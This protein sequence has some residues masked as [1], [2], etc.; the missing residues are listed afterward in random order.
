M[1]LPIAGMLAAFLSFVLATPFV[2]TLRRPNLEFSDP[3]SH[4]TLGT[5][6][7]LVQHSAFGLLLVGFFVP[8]L[9]LGRRP[10]GQV[11]IATLV[12]SVVGGLLSVGFDAMLDSIAISLDRSSKRTETGLGGAGSFIVPHFYGLFQTI[13]LAFP[14]AFASGATKNRFKRAFLATAVGTVLSAI[15]RNVI[16]IVMIPFAI[17]S[18]MNAVS[19]NP[20]DLSGVLAASIPSWQASAIAVGLALGLTMGFVEYVTRTGV[21][22]RVYARNEFKEWE[23]AGSH[24]RIGSGEVEIRVDS[25]HGVEPIH[26]VLSSQGNQHVLDSRFAPTLVNGIPIG[27]QPL[28][29]GDWIQ[30]GD[31]EMIYLAKDGSGGF[32]MTRRPAQAPLTTN[33]TAVPATPADQRPLSLVDSSGARFVLAG[34][35]HT[36]GRDLGN[37]I[38]LAKHT[39][40]S[41]RHAVISKTQHGEELRDAGS[42][43]GTF[44]NGLRLTEPVLLSP[45][46]RVAFGSATF[47]V[48]G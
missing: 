16:G 11:L 44:H 40:V 36:V 45:G 22:R 24:L 9:L 17:S 47:I 4:Y 18:M 28:R 29:H 14:I 32:D 38:V 21:L 10:I 23:L 46:D 12:W 35:E 39:T 43:N 1:P 26:A 42:S 19:K 33:L 34:G 13:A 5:S 48:E 37:S 31:V 15:A 20:S 30:M 7:A 41:R 27:V 8:I 25:S 3:A 2:G 6:W